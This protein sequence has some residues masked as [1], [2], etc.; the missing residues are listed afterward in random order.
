[1]DEYTIRLLES[2][3]DM[4]MVEDL[5]R[6]IWPGSEVEIVPKHMLIAAI[7]NGGVI[8]GA[9]VKDQ[10][11]GFVYGFPGLEALPDG[12]QPKHCS[13]M[14]GVHPDWRNFGLGFALKRAQW[15][16]VRRQ[17]LNHVTWTYDPLL[18]K[19]AYL[20]ISKLG[21]VCNTY[22]ISEY[23]D[24]QDG[25]NAGLP[26]DRFMVDWWIN[27]RRVKHRLGK[28]ARGKLNLDQ[29]IKADLQPIYTPYTGTD[30]LSHPPEHFS[31]FSD[32]ILL[33]E[34]PADFAALKTADFSL[35]RDWRFFAR[36]FFET[37]F[38]EGYLVTDFIFQVGEEDPRS[39]YILTNGETTLEG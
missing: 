8:L 30:G 11:A 18:S 13:H 15:Q 35:A 20:N 1:M 29:Y 25:L 22:R 39:L 27:T 2:P 31:T 28:H 33:A 16:M 21:A 36:E 17:G 5:Q 6:I 3:D 4:T 37:A 38:A 32:S 19:N 26:S 14:M 9:F 7:H 23:G 10:L 34:I 24:M 12:P